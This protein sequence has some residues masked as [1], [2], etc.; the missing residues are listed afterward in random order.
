MKWQGRSWRI[1]SEI[2]LSGLLAFATPTK[3]PVPGTLNYLEGQATI[4]GKLLSSASIGGEVVGAGQVLNTQNG[5][6][7]MLLTPGV[8]LRLGENS[9]VRMISSGLAEMEVG[10]DRGQATVEADYWVKDNR[11]RIDENG[12]RTDILK[13]GLY[14]LGAEQPYVQVLEGK[15]EVSANDQ[16]VSVGKNRE[17][18]V[19]PSGK[20]KTQDFN[21]KAVQE[22]TLLRWSRL[23]SEYEAQANFDAAR[24]VIVDNRWYGP[25]WYW[26]PSFGY[27]SFLPGEG[28]LYSPFGWGFYSPFYVYGGPY[29]Y[30]GYRGYSGRPFYPRTGIVAP[31]TGVV[32]PRSFTGGGLV[33]AGRHR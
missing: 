2:W 24:T 26:G 19:D 15:A 25:G 14:L 16:H 20:L 28:I 27:W 17:A 7:E 9:E 4:D 8:F 1:A 23:R 31:R 10:L 33:G 29:F 21:S 6:V 13:K 5:K 3:T 12:A 32:A 30:G 22:G 11:L 18:S